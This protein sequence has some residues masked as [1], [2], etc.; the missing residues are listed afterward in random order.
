MDQKEHNPPRRSTITLLIALSILFTYFTAR[1]LYLLMEAHY[2]P[3]L[4][5]RISETL[6]I[7]HFI[8]GILL[9]S[10]VCYAAFLARKKFCVY[11]FAILYGV[12]MSLTY[13]EAL[14]WVYLDGRHSEITSL[15]TTGG[16]ALIFLSL[17]F[18]FVSKER[19]NK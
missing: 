14:M 8:Y 11:F 2:I 13:D 16:I 4:S 10:F 7:H 12:G 6:H 15:C 18:I 9:L 17:Y 1:I 19:E 5:L 3:S